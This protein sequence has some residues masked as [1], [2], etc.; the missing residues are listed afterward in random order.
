MNSQ[1]VDKRPLIF[2]GHGQA[3]AEPLL[4]QL[5]FGSLP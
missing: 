4:T 1:L 2:G 3:V 5:F